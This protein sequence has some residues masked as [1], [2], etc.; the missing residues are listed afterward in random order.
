MMRRI[1]LSAIALLCVAG[2]ASAAPIVLPAGTPIYFQ[3]NNLEQTNLSNSIIIPGGYNGVNT[4]GN[5]GVFN[6]SSMQFGSPTIP[7]IDISGGPTFFNDDGPGGTQGMITGIFYGVQNTSA[8]TANGGFID[9]FWHDAGADTT[10]GATI[11][12]EAACLSGS[13]CGPTAA[14]VTAFTTGTFLAR[15]AF[16]SGIDPLNPAVFIKGTT[17]P[18]TI[19]ASG[20][21]DSF[22]NVVTSAGGAW[23]TQLDGNWFT[24]P[25]GL[26]DVRFS[27]FFNGLP[28]WATPSNAATGTTVGLRSNDPGR[29]FTSEVIPEPA[30]LT[31][32]GLGLAGLARRRRRKV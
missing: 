9:L 28:A 26:R 22:A 13:T 4:Q 11:A 31:L 10:L 15:L 18:T 6:V 27:N 5:W 21:A 7:H 32:L 29:V 20:E 30:S 25:F 14:T 23:A 19:N 16:A 24:T 1:A 3:F 2:T 17:D 8:T 12:A